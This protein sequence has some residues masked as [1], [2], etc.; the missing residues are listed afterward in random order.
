MSRRIF[1]PAL[2]SL[3]SLLMGIQASAAAFNV[4]VKDFGAIADG[5]TKA[6]AA[7]QKALDTVAVNGGGEVLV[8]SGRYLIGSIQMGTRTILRLEKDTVI[9]GSPDAA[10]Y[11]NMEIR[12][13]GRWQQGRRALIYAA[14]V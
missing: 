12:W 1:M 11:P 13:E 10:D 9:I 14:N 8:P 7:F 2:P 5:K 6:T 4:S 3:I